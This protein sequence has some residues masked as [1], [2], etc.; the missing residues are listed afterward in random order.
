[1]WVSVWV[2][3]GCLKKEHKVLTGPSLVWMDQEPIHFRFP[4]PLYFQDL[5]RK[6]KCIT[7]E[8]KNIN[9]TNEKYNSRRQ[10]P[11]SSNI[12]LLENLLQFLKICFSFSLTHS[13]CILFRVLVIFLFSNR[14]IIVTSAMLHVHSWKNFTIRYSWQGSAHISYNYAFPFVLLLSIWFS[15]VFYSTISSFHSEK[16]PYKAYEQLHNKKNFIKPFR[17]WKWNVQNRS[18]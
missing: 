8:R 17:R 18:L 9:R 5:T 12:C 4:R 3:C 2:A 15:F 10:V 13:K 11:N 14:F 1:M 16:V 7:N 6:A